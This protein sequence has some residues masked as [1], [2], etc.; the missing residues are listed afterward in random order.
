MHPPPPFQLEQKSMA[1]TTKFNM[2]LILALLYLINL[3]SSQTNQFFP[4]S[5]R[6]F[7]SA[8]CTN[9]YIRNSNNVLTA[10]W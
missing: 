6:G 1:S 5:G 4:E 10:T 9:W 3:V 2:L 7:L 8:G